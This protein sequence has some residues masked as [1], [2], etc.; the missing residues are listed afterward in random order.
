MHILNQLSVYKAI[1]KLHWQCASRS[2]RLLSP[3]S[4]LKATQHRTVKCNYT[5]FS[6]SQTHFLFSIAFEI[7]L[8]T[9][10]AVTVSPALIKYHNNFIS[11]EKVILST[12]FCWTN[13]LQEILK[14]GRL[15]LLWII[16]TFIWFF[17]WKFVRG[18]ICLFLGALR[19]FVNCFSPAC[20]AKWSVID[21]NLKC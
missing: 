12:M 1:E 15:Y 8:A 7:V 4:G 16:R 18:K 3:I 11:S 17:G 5:H 13:S 14:N 2:A 10:R 6:L 9:S 19:D 20:D 21:G